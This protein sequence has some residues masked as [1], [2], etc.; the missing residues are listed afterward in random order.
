[1][2]YLDIIKINI[3][4]LIAKNLLTNV[5]KANKYSNVAIFVHTLIE[6]QLLKQQLYHIDDQLN[7][8]T[9]DGLHQLQDA[10]KPIVTTCTP[11]LSSYWLLLLFLF[12]KV[13][14]IVGDTMYLFTLKQTDIGPDSLRVLSIVN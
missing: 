7:C 12:Y 11:K 2:H 8:S 9:N 14:I 4:C 5:T 10:W 13:M 6:Q 3:E 1:M